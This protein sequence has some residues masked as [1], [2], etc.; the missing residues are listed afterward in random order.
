[1]CRKVVHD[2]VCEGC[3]SEAETIG[4]LFWMCPRAREVW[5]YSKIVVPV[6]QDRCLL[7][8]DLLWSMLAEERQ[9]VEMVAKVVCIVW[10]RWHNWNKVRHGGQCRNG[11]DMVRWAPQY[12]EEYKVATKSLSYKVEVVEVGG[13]WN[14]PPVNI[15]KINVD[16]T[17]F[18][19]QKAVGVG[20]IIRDNKGRIEAAMSKKIPI[21]LGA[22]EAEAMAYKTGLIFAKDI[23]I[24]D[25]IVEGDSLIIHHAMCESSNPPSSMAAVVQVMQDMC[26]EFRAIMFSHVRRKGNRP[27]HLLAK[28]ACTVDDFITW[29]EETPCFLEQALL[30][31]VTNSSIH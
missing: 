22:V 17:V 14:S 12:M 23:G 30:H 10:A 4:H 27:A 29:I 25:F 26:K 1:M 31:D 28:H 20:V 6:D 5:S 15:F 16:G 11:K 21:L 3:S 9:D 2:Q 18:T 19:D 13:T 24:H 7:F 8:H